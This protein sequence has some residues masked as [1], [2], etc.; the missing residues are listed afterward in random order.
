MWLRSCE[1]VSLK[2]FEAMCRIKTKTALKATQKLETFLFT[3]Y[4]SVAT[5]QRRNAH[6]LVFILRRRR[7]C[8]LTIFQVIS[9]EE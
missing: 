8:G 5:R 2:L 7:V 3:A 4:D 9:G 6:F 1:S